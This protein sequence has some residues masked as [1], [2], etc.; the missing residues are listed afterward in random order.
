LLRAGKVVAGVDIA[1]ERRPAARTDRELARGPARLASALGLSRADN[2]ADVC[3]PGSAMRVLDGSGVD[4]VRI[5]SGPRVGL[6]R[7]A[8]RPW[9][10]WLDGDPTVSVYRPHTPRRRSL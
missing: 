4:P 5:R 2:G 8:D 7:A 3:A 10:F 1:R 9:R 6:S